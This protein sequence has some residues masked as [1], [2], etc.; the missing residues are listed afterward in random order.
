MKNLFILSLIL[1]VFCIINMN[2]QDFAK[3]GTWEFG[4]AVSYTSTTNVNDGETADNSTNEFSFE[5]PVGYFIIDGL[6]LGITPEIMTTSYDDR[7]T[8][9]FG[10]YFTPAWNFDLNSNAYPFIEGR[11]GYQSAT[12]D[13]GGSSSSSTYS[14][15]GWGVLG[16]VKVQIS[17]NVLI[18]AG[19]GYMQHT[20]EG[21]NH[22]GGRNGENILGG[23]VGI[24]VFVK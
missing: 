3:E 19:F 14:G 9:W 7:S 23:R 13:P 21:E 12:V 6:E 18:N 1:S 15:I 5:V 17:K 16:G 24:I 20:L 22:T 8:T 11:F 2:A 10:I 4:G